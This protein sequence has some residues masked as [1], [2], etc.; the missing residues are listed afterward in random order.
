MSKWTRTDSLLP[1]ESV[2]VETMD[3]EGN[4]SILVRKGNLFFLPDLSMYVYYVPVR[5][6]EV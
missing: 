6:R 2:E 4:T 3:N 5:W 1:P